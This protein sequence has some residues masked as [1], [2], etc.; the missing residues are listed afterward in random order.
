MP[1]DGQGRD[2]IFLE[3]MR[4]EMKA[5]R[6][7]LSILPE[8]KEIVMEHSERLTGIDGRLVVLEDIAREHSA[9][10]GQ[11]SEDITE[12]KATLGQHGED[13]T[14]IKHAVV[15]LQAASHTH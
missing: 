9:I 15:G 14:E 1:D 12:I 2:R 10:L 4:G 11:H 7:G 13:L 3:E 6:E 5:L 8:I